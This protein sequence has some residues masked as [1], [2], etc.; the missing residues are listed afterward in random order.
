M[1]GT[2][3]RD[4]RECVDRFGNIAVDV[5]IGDG[6]GAGIRSTG[7]SATPATVAAFLR[8]LADDVAALCTVTIPERQVK[9]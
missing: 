5:T 7:A 4:L 8:D 9:P 6:P 2:G 1:S 3:G